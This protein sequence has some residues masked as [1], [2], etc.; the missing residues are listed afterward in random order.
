METALER[1][2]RIRKTIDELPPAAAAARIE[3]ALREYGAR[4]VVLAS[5]LSAEDQVLTH[6]L[7]AATPHPR[8]FTIDT[9]RLFNET[10][11]ALEQ[12]M[13][14]YGIGYEVL[15]PDAAQLQSMV[16]QEGPNLF[17]K[18]VEQRKRCCMVRKI[19]PLKRVLSSASL[20]ICGLRREQSITRDTIEVVEWDE[21]YGLVKL[22]PLCDWSEEQV[23]HYVRDQAIPYN[24]LQQCGLRSVG[25]MPCTRAIGAEED[26]RAGR[27]WW[28][29]PHHKECGL[30]Q[31]NQLGSKQ[32]RGENGSS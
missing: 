23:W 31:R 26:V 8:I 12:T 29:E 21:A 32:Q 24:P 28:E 13:Q 3:V 5:S 6:L 10:Y 27:W 16:E 20:W 19:E 4:Q 1:F 7:A 18:G 11:E 30:H 9:G 22:N 25:C 14:R 15:Y 2:E 17:Y